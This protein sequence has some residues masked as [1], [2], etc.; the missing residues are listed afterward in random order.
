MA[1][2]TGVVTVLTITP[3]VFKLYSQFWCLNMCFQIQR[4]QRSWYFLLRPSSSMT[5]SVRLSVRL[6]ICPSVCPSHL[7][8]YVP[9]II[10]SWIFQELL[11]WK[12]V[13]PMQK[14]KVRTQRSRS[15]R[16][17]IKLSG[18][19]TYSLN[20]HMAMKSGTQL[21]VESKRCP[22]VFPGHL[23]NFE[24]TGGKSCRFSPDIGVSGL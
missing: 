7:F 1:A 20:S 3:A 6:S 19:R 4:S 23:S 10:S 18:F 5:V 24:V 16:S 12:K 15:Q 17:K 2:V 8:H 21:E 11:P 13:M 9:I 22:I 14:A